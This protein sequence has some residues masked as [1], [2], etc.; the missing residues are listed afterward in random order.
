MLKHLSFIKAIFTFFLPYNSK[1]NAV[2]KFWISDLESIS[3]NTSI[4]SKK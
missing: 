1:T 3:T 4:K 2:R